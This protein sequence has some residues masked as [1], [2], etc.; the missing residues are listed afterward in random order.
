MA[1]EAGDVL[2]KHL[3]KL[4]YSWANLALSKIIDKHGFNP[5]F[6]MPN[7]RKFWMFQF[8][9]SQGHLKVRK[10]FRDTHGIIS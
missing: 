7:F 10:N 8:S 3:P 5:H 4:S 1:F 2:G 9:D 6:K